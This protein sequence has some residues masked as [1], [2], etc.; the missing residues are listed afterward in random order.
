MNST[1]P[2][3]NIHP[4][5]PL[6]L[7]GISHHT[8][9]V[10]VRDRVALS[11]T[12]QKTLLPQLRDR[13]GA[14]G[15]LIMSTCNRTEIYLSGPQL[16]DRLNDLR[17]WLDAL[18]GTAYFADEQL[19]Y[20]R[21]GP[22]AVR[23]FFA[24]IAGLDSQIIGEQQIT[25]Q[26]KDGYNLAHDLEA[27]DALLNK[28]F[29]FA[30][31]AKKRVYNETLLYDGTVSVSFAGVEL[32]RKIFNSLEDKEILLIGAGKTAELAAFHFTE[33]G[34]RT[35]HVAN[36]SPERARELAAKTGGRAWTL[37]ELPLALTS[38]DIAISATGSSDYI[39]S[40]AAMRQVGRERR[41]R[42]LF[43][44]DL[45]VPRDIE[46]GVGE[47]DGV[48]LY[49]LDD[50][51]E[52]VRSNLENRR[53]EIP[54][55]MKIIGEVADE[56][57]QWLSSYSMTAIIGRLKEHLEALRLRELE[58][59]K[60][61]L[62]SNGSLKEI[63]ELTQGIM[64]KLIRQHVKSLKRHAADPALYQQHVDLIYNLYELDRGD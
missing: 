20:H 30:M 57:L 34:A 48:Y 42:P 63:D 61:R 31:Q 36:R 12:E 21:F 3:G 9:P 26:V 22:E 27:T 55:A 51:E 18:K 25:A 33:S 11:E 35:I 45:A 2:S 8:A 60:K 47:L 5:V 23:H 24:L 15:A 64:N 17:A 56:Y 52:I 32:A 41:H 43:L 38:A 40:A 37:D 44:I 29:N 1:E 6:V 16:D 7:L 28:L 50:L 19:T 13:F 62:P 59:M 10:E 49:N 4:E 58:R 14:E 54:K 53:K 39:L 46:P